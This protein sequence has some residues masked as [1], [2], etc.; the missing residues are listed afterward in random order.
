MAPVGECCRKLGMFLDWA[1]DGG[2]GWV[3]KVEILVRSGWVKEI[4][5]V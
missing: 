4:G 5:G 2:V 1:F 3:E